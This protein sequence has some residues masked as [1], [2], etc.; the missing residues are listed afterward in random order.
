VLLACRQLNAADLNNPGMFRSQGAHGSQRGLVR[1]FLV[2]G[3]PIHEALMFLVLAEFV[4]DTAFEDLNEPIS[5]GAA[6]V[7]VLGKR[8]A[9]LPKQILQR[10]SPFRMVGVPGNA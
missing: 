2:L 8:F 10:V 4:L 3:I 9:N 5:L 1:I 6:L 7:G